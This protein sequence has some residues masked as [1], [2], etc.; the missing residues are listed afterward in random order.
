VGRGCRQSQI[1]QVV[2]PEADKNTSACSGLLHTHTRS[3][4]VDVSG[5]VMAVM[6]GVVWMTVGVGSS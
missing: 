2:S 4:C 3:T 1:L 5:A 6:I